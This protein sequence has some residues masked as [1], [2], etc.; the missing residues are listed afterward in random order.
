MR[1]ALS[2]LL[3]L[4]MVFS[5]VPMAAFADTAAVW[6]AEGSYTAVGGNYYEFAPTSAGN[7]TFTASDGVLFTVDNGMGF[8]LGSDL[9]TWSNEMQG[10]GGR[11]GITPNADTVITITKADAK[12]AIDWVEYKNEDDPS[13]FY[14]SPCLEIDENGM[15]ALACLSEP[16]NVAGMFGAKYA[17]ESTGTYIDYSNALAEYVANAVTIGNKLYTYNTYDI[18]QML[19]HLSVQ[20]DWVGL[21]YITSVDEFFVSGSANHKETHTEKNGDYEYVICN[22]CK[23]LVSSTQPGLLEDNPIAVDLSWEGTVG[24]AS[25]TADYWYSFDATEGELFVNDQ[26]WWY[27]VTDDGRAVTQVWVE[28]E[29]EAPITVEIKWVKPAPEVT[30]A[31]PF[32][33]YINQEN[34]G[35]TLYVTGAMSG[36]YGAT[37][38][39]AADGADFYTETSA[40]G[41]RIYFMDG[42]TKKY[43]EIIPSGTYRNVKFNT[44]PS[45]YYT[46]DAAHETYITPVEGED[47]YLGT[48]GT[49]NTLSASKYSYIE[50]SFPAHLGTPAVEPDEPDV[51]DVPVVVP[52]TL[53]EQIAEAN[54]LANKEYLPYE[55]TITG[56]I[57]DEPQ[58]S[59][60]NEG[61][62]KF[63]VSDGTNSLMCY[64]VP[65]T[66][67][68][69]AK[70]DAVTVT[71]YLTAHNGS[72]QFDSTAAAVVTKATE[73]EEPEEPEDPDTTGAITIVIADYASENGWENGV[74]YPTIEKDGITVTAAGGENTGKY[75]NNGT[76]WRLYQTESATVTISADSSI[77]SVKVTYASSNSGELQLDGV[78]VASEETVAVNGNSVTFAVGGTAA[79]QNGQARIT[80]IEVVLGGSAPSEP[81][82][83]E[84]AENPIYP[85][86]VWN[87][88][89]TEATCEVTLGK[90][91]W[92]F[93]D[94]TMAGKDL[95]VNGEPYDYIPG[96]PRMSPS[97]WTITNDGAEAVYV[98]KIVTPL[99]DQSNPE[100]IDSLFYSSFTASLA[101][102]DT[103]GYYYLYTAEG[104]GSITMYITDIPEGIT[105]D[106]VAY[107]LNTYQMLTLLADGVDNAGL[108]LTMEVSE[109][110][111]IQ[112]QVMVAPD[113]SWNIAAADIT[114]FGT[115]TATPGTAEN[116]IAPEWVWNDEYTEA[117][118]EVTLGQGTWYFADWTMA[119]KDLLVNGEPYDYIP[120][121]PRMSPST[122]TIT[123]DGAEAA[124]VLKIVTPV[125]DQSNPEIIDSL[126]YS[127]FTASLAEGDSDGYYYLYTAEGDGSITMYINDIP[128]GITGDIVAYNLNTYQMLTLLADG[129]DN[130][131]LELTMEVSEGD[132]IQI[133]VM[134]APDD[135][136]NIAAADITWFGNFTAK[137]GSEANPV[138]VE[139]EN[140]DTSAVIEFTYEIPAGETVYFQ[141]RLGGTTLEM[142]AK[143]LIVMIDDVQ[144][145]AE[146][147]IITYEFA[148]SEGFFAPPNQIV[149]TNN[150]NEAV[151]ADMSFTYAVGSDANP[152]E[153][154]IGENTAK[155]GNGGAGYIYN[156]I[157]EE[158]GEL[159][160]TMN[161]ENWT[162]VINNMTSYAYGENHFA[163]DGVNSETVSVAAG[164]EI[165]IVIGT[166]D[167][168][169]ATIAFTTAF[170]NG[171]VEEPACTH[172]TMNFVEEVKPTCDA[173]GNIAHYVCSECGAYFE[174]EA[175]THEIL[176]AIRVILPALEHEHIEY[177]AEI[178]AECHSQ[179]TKEHWFCYDCGNYYAD[180]ALTQEIFS[181]EVV[182][183]AE[184]PELTFVAEVEATCG[185]QGNIAHY[186]CEECGGLF[187]D[188]AGTIQILPAQRVVIP[189]LEHASVEHFDEVPAQCHS[190]GMAEHWFC[191]D[192]GFY[193]ADE[194]LTQQVFERD[195]ILVGEAPELT[196]VEAVEATCESNGVMEHYE[197]PECGGLFEDE[198]GTIQI[199][200]AQRVVI[201]AL[202]HANVEFF[203]EVPAQCHSLGM[204]AHW[205]CADCGNY[206]LDEALTQEVFERDLVLV[207]EAPEL[208]KVERVEATCDSNGV[209]EHYACPECGGLFEDEAG[210]IQILPAQRVVIPALDH[211]NVEFFAEVPA[212]CHSLGM[213]AHWFCADCGNY[214]LDEALTQEVF[215]RDLVLVAEAPEL[216]KVERVEAT[217]DSNG[218]M[219][220]YACPECGG[221]FEDEAGTIQILPA[222][223]VVI[224]ALEHANVEHFD[225]V[226]A[227]CHS[228]GMAEH[229]FCADCG[230]YYTDAALTHEVFEREL[231]LPATNP[232][233]VHVERVEPSCANGVIEHWRCEE[234]GGAF[235]DEAGMHQI[236]PAQRVII[237]ATGEHDIDMNNLIWS[238]AADKKSAEAFTYCDS[239]ENNVI[240]YAD[241]VEEAPLTATSEQYKNI[242]T[243]YHYYTATVTYKD[244]TYTNKCVVVDPTC[245]HVGFTSYYGD[246][247]IGNTVYN[248]PEYT[249][250]FVMGSPWGKWEVKNKLA[251]VWVEEGK[252]GDANYKKYCTNC[253][254]DYKN[255][256]TGDAIMISV[257]IMVLAGAAVVVMLTKKRRFA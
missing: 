6:T 84:S 44:E 54:K 126:S 72:A 117:T 145:N 61:Q 251:H 221:L 234:C 161:G 11:I 257:I 106:I 8:V 27:E 115:F 170:S 172:A 131:G 173:Q 86:W 10:D 210:T 25:V 15:Y 139:D 88:E 46:F 133:Q 14:F 70:G 150:G 85:E 18:G 60:Y 200:P 205:F 207:A 228:Q 230:N 47:Y 157:A 246:V 147:G 135:S 136:W 121:T 3:V 217:C 148:P 176:P 96:T 49:Y 218:V 124:Y 110:D 224:P 118:Y 112:I 17:D 105:G 244:Q 76:N 104:D 235:E 174:D 111:Q 69:P 75:Y 103:D 93:A 220:H 38:E 137:P 101:E 141:G 238:W 192:C 55:S 63:T 73:P 41:V 242:S 158:D 160:I 179:G 1:R 188:A 57:T 252:V 204:G 43:V 78:T 184:Y 79:K 83:G 142:D 45:I 231:I 191:S 67:G 171:E 56:T 71:G 32:K 166:E 227:Q 33:M 9:E 243:V 90:G 248:Y 256:A 254:L 245:R 237:P 123:N 182:I 94:W 229:W 26:Q 92:Y 116:P 226:P 16:V 113:D 74:Q 156:W 91:T 167:W 128:E 162:F 187:E 213:G 152:A 138:L 51:P 209:M 149:I 29:S 239:C 40:E 132:Q 189:A 203:A 241:V 100:I 4:V 107:N 164:D 20:N 5:M 208:T 59:S 23:Q 233:L 82:P 24:T 255:V 199:L 66:G 247:L 212:Q 143:D 219:E 99:G 120:G 65:V 140:W 193:Y 154:V 127:S 186:L 206:Y 130:A 165:Q 81:I 155:P 232:A 151:A 163:S 68:T 108:E 202:D 53:A 34:L 144:V 35:K 2:W 153:L 109:G 28:N 214:Y 183:P 36:Y 50:T 159:T 177:N 216:T 37:S 215:E 236:L 225:E 12:P 181:F 58:A 87:E 39:N 180:E 13:N 211:A 119:G 250:D 197:C 64:Y 222:Q 114:W 129:V 249:K 185:S 19:Q 52:E 175:G 31:G 125:G 77:A 102:G 198:A 48:Y 201:P 122:W 190:L 178:P 89:Y 97:T 134:V 253:N 146:N 62:Y 196:K 80:A 21:G 22:T 195:L 240:F 98:L 169:A 30:V 223:R 42:N 7:Y 95:L 168:T 194:A